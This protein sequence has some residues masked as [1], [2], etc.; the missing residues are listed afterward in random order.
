LIESLG[1]KKQPIGRTIAIAYL[2]IVLERFVERQCRT[3]ALLWLA[4]RHRRWLPTDTNGWASMGYALVSLRHFTAANYW[5]RDWRNRPGLRMWML[6]NLA[7]SL[8][9]RWRW[10]RAREVLALAVTLPEHD[11]TFQKLRLLLAMEL[12]MA[13]D[14]QHATEHFRELDSTGWSIYMLI[15]RRLCRGLLA[16]QTAPSEKVRVF[17]S[18]RRDI[19]KLLAKHGLS[20]IRMDYWRSICRMARDTG[21]KWIVFLTWV[22]F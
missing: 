4:W 16:V 12:A 8:R 18:E 17:R 7:L 15:Q 2:I 13:G 9:E 14:T 10:Q 19:H 1:Q 21:S 5:M 20:R 22:G 3:A 11:D 6:L